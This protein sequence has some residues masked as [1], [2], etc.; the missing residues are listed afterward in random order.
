MSGTNQMPGRGEDRSD[1]SR[2][3]AVSSSRS[4][5]AFS[6]FLILVA[7]IA[8]V[9]GA[10][11]LFRGLRCEYWPATV[12]VIRTAEMEHIIG[13]DSNSSDTYSARITYDYQVTGLHY[14]STRLAF[15]EMSSS[16]DYAQGILSRYRVGRKVPVHYDPNNPGLAVLETGI[17]GGTWICFGVGTVLLLAGWMFLQQSS[18][19]PATLTEVERQQ[20]PKL[21]GVIF[22]VVGSFMFFMEPDRGVPAWIAYAVGGAFVLM[23][24]FVLACH[25]QNKRYSKILMWAGILPLLV[26]FHWVSFGA[27][28][29]TGTI[30]IPFFQGSGVSVRPFFAGIMVLIDLIM[31]VSILALGVR[32]LINGRKN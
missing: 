32:R 3:E 13:H 5:R 29:R 22:I 25:W 21:M 14:T 17:H 12:G 27:G 7:V 23:G 1:V 6:W 24:L 15:G 30:T 19:N 4:T 18:A 26:V 9:F 20:P 11:N 28:E 2:R 8:I 10:G 16:P 31:L